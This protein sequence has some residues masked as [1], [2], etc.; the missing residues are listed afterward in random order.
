MQKRYL[1]LTFI[2]SLLRRGNIVAGRTIFAV[3]STLLIALW[4]S[5]F[6][7]GTL[8][9]GESW[10]YAFEKTM[11]S[12][13]MSG[14]HTYESTFRGTIGFVLDSIVLKPDGT[15]WYFTVTDRNTVFKRT[16]N[17]PNNFTYD[18]V[19]TDTASHRYM[20]TING[21][22]LTAGIDTG[23]FSFYSMPDAVDSSGSFQR[24]KTSDTSIFINNNQVSAF[25]RTT[26]R[27]FEDKNTS[28]VTSGSS[29]D[30][31]LWIDSLGVAYRKISYSQKTTYAESIY[32]SNEREVL[33]LVRHNGITLAATPA[34]KTHPKHTIHQIITN[35]HGSP[36]Y[37][38]LLGKAMPGMRAG[39]VNRGIQIVQLPDGRSTKQVLMR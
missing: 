30:S 23:L 9:Q 15:F 28:A 31:I 8:K 36:R 27:R 24:M 38:S 21:G 35:V 20:C 22:M 18:T 2:N 17:S 12:S 11:F 5:A 3:V 4:G 26:N 10:E 29:Y 33:T 16:K 6:G 39:R 32:E 1:K 25:A 13:L 7:G 37:V 34:V 14:V 19:V